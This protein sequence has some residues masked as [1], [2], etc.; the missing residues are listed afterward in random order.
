LHKKFGGS[1]AVNAKI[2]ERTGANFE[3]KKIIEMW[4]TGI[5]HEKYNQNLKHL[6]ITSKK[7]YRN[8][9]QDQP[10]AA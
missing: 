8:K 5:P 3:T 9:Y 2:G 10:R 4:I 1:S 7:N 6:A